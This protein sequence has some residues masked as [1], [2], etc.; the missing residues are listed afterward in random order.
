MAAMELL[1][2]VGN[3]ETFGAALDGGADAVYVGAPGFNA[4]NLAR[5]VRL[6]EI[7]AMIDHCHSLDKKLYIAANS[8][9][10]ERELP[11]VIENL[12][13]L[14]ELNPDALIVQDL[15]LIRLVRHYF[16]EL[17]LHGSTLTTVHNSDGVRYQA[18]LGCERVVLARELTLKEIGTIAAGRGPTELEIFIHGAMCFSYSGLC[19]FSSYLGGK[20]GLRGRCVQPCRRAYSS[21]A[22]ITG[23]KGAKD[24]GKK[25]DSGRYLFS[26]NDLT[27]LEAVPF[28]KEAGISSLKIEGRLRS[29]HYVHSIV[30]AYRMVLDADLPHQ[31]EA[32]EQAR[33]LA[34]QAMSRKTTSGYFFSPQPAEAT[35]PHHSGNMGNHLGRFTV[36]RMVGDQ[37]T[38][39]FVTKGSLS[40][41]DRLRLHV[42][43]SGERTAFRLKSMF[44]LGEKKENAVAGSKV[45]IELPAGFQAAAN[46][47]VEVYKV[48]GGA[49]GASSYDGASQ[50]ARIGRE[51]A[52]KK[53]QLAA[54]IDRIVSLV[55][56][57]GSDLPDGEQPDIKRKAGASHRPHRPQPVRKKLPMDWWLKTDSLKLILGDLPLVPDRY[58]LSFNK[59]TVSQAGKM[60]GALGKKARMLTWALPPLIMENDL[61]KVKKQIQLLLRT[62]FRSFQLGHLSQRLLFKGEKAHLFAD[63]TANL[64]NNQALAMVSELGIGAAQAGIEMDR[65]A[66]QELLNGCRA[67]G[68]TSSGGRSIPVGL[69]VYG[70]PALYTSRLAPDYFP[71][72]KQILSPRDEPYVIRKKEGYTQ[73]FPDKPFSLLPYLDELKEMGVKYAVVDIS[74]GT[75]S[76]RELQDLDDRLHNTGRYGKLSTFN[77]L[78]KLE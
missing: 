37:L 49:Q 7:G 68:S 36:T 42:E 77:Y 78:G 38:C 14:A 22:R 30:A 25:G 32:L 71:Y 76:K 62:G 50:V 34:D 23:G 31:D 70:A 43:P 1:A 61:P 53:K 28:L 2:P 75:S 48:D 16:P 8:L 63:Y 58:L 56:D 19:L 20:S 44:V 52:V 13:L 39:R 9:I 33:V 12:A 74:G 59:Q 17:R 6:E 65:A 67:G 5:D 10:L 45:S 72:D 41:G 35:S 69:M 26:M 3:A 29:A 46:G 18:D 51:L 54:T 47:H 57:T 60:K 4:R 15:G 11:L 66:L 55:C 24:A 64:F 21:G 40:V 27:G 73:T